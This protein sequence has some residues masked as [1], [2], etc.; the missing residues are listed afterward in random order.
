[1]NMMLWTALML[2]V[3]GSLH[4]IGMC[5]PIALALPVQN[6][7]RQFKIAGILTYN[8]GRAVTYAA[9]G[10]LAGLAGKTVSWMG[11]QQA[12]SI[13]AGTIILVLLVLSLIGEKIPL[14]PMLTGIYTAVRKALGK[15]FQNRTVKGFFLIGLLNGLLP[16][17]LVYAALAGAGATGSVWEGAVFMFVFGMGTLPAMFALPYAGAFFSSAFRG[18][19]RKAVPVFVGVMAVLLIIRGMGLDIPYLSPAPDHACCHR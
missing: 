1:M 11:G 17:G 10:A 12:L 3:V 18:R 19:L 13:T 6:R 8:F 5:G 7:S 15:L 2:G 9:L 14:P 4:C 16:C